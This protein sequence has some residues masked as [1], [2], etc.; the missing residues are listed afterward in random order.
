MLW[1]ARAR[2]DRAG[3]DEI[4]PLFASEMS[5]RPFACVHVAGQSASLR[6]DGSFEEVIAGIGEAEHL[7]RSR[8]PRARCRCIFCPLRS[9]ARPR[10]TAI[11]IRKERGLGC[12]NFPGSI[13][14]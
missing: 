6:N 1:L 14:R 12:E 5:E 7:W 8:L 4:G 9:S 2:S 3:D 11:K 13:P 10:L